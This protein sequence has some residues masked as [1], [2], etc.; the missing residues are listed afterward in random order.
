[1]LTLYRRVVFGEL[2]N[3]KL[4]TIRDVTLLETFILG[5]LAV[6]ALGLG[7]FPALIFDLTEGST[8]EVLRMI[9]QV[10]Q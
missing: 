8:S 1:M 5:L 6:S 7:V 2:T 10:G 3:E 9:G 4:M